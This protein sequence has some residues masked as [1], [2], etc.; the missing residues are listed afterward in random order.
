MKLLLTGKKKSHEGFTSQLV[1]ETL[2][3]GPAPGPLG[4]PGELRDGQGFQ[5]G[6]HLGHA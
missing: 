3:S 4:V 6:D 2:C 5:G 1:A